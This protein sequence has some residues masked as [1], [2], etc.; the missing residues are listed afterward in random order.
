MSPTPTLPP[1]TPV[2]PSLEGRRKGRS[3]TGER[4]TSGAPTHTRRPGPASPEGALRV[5]PAPRR[6]QRRKRA[7]Q[8]AVCSAGVSSTRAG[9]A[10]E[11]PSLEWGAPLPGGARP[12]G[13]WTQFKEQLLGPG[14]FSRPR[15]L[16]LRV[17]ALRTKGEKVPP[18]PGLALRA[19]LGSQLARAGGRGA[20]TLREK[21]WEPDRS[22][23]V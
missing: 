23:P 9:R 6:P 5:L 21:R 17:R 3:L 15:L 19:C 1:A 8:R 11:S 22:A 7:S 2:F 14:Y 16:A 13:V 20:G 18:A 4:E 10:H 12:G